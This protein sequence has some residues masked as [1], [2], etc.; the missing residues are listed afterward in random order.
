MLTGTFTDE[1]DGQTYKTV[2]F[3]NQTWMAENL[4]YH[5]SSGSWCYGEDG[6][7]IMSER[8]LSSKEI[9]A[10]CDKYGRLYD[11][12]TA[13][14]I[15]PVGWH[16][17]SREEWNDLVSAVGGTDAAGKKLKSKSGWKKWDKWG[18]GNGTDEYGFSALPGGYRLSDGRFGYAGYNGLWWTSTKSFR[19][20]YAYYWH[21]SCPCDLGLRVAGVHVDGDKV[22]ESDEPKILVGLSVRCVQ[23]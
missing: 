13:M 18:S 15:C 20:D 12:E 10:Y 11:W 19:S 3:G 1:R 4:N 8:K 23:D 14:A 17:P 21:M 6:Y 16:L 9:Q 7:D 22:Y 2:K 5:A